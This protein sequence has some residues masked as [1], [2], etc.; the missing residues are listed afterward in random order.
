MV[1]TPRRE[2]CQLSACPEIPGPA[3]SQDG[4]CR[5]TEV[6]NRHSGPPKYWSDSTSIAEYKRLKYTKEKGK[7]GGRKG[8]RKEGRE[9]GRKKG[10]REEG[11]KEA[12]KGRMC[13]GGC[14]CVC[15]FVRAC[16]LLKSFV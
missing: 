8:T 6:D 16:L 11:R 9:G 10:R 2:L 5:V 7:Q 12:K 14:L 4:S 15:V 1:C 3:A 13:A